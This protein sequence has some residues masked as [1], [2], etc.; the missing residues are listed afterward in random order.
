MTNATTLRLALA[1]AALS[2]LA[3]AGANVPMTSGASPTGSY[4]LQSLSAWRAYKG[5]TIPKGWLVVDGTI[6]KEGEAEDL[7]SREQYGNFELSLDWKLAPG[8]NAGIFYRGTEEYE[9]IYWSA[10]EYQLL[11]DARHPDGRNRLT[12]AA[13]AYGLYAP[14]AG[15]VKPA[16]EWNSTR[17]V[18]RGNH[19]E[20]W[21]NG[22]KVVE[23]ELLSPDW[24]SKV[25]ASKFG[26]WPHYGLSPRG[27]IGIQGDHDGLLS[28]RNMSI[29]VLP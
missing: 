3:C 6:T 21:L 16:G 25:K 7:V 29:T 2:V 17:I 28:L 11:D 27:Y 26:E 5:M 12:S 18:A 14:P 4:S 23:Y 10:P 15:V 9:H 13:S 20:H 22:Q 24:A 1:G 8:G 19:I